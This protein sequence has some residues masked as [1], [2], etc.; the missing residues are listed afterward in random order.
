[1]ELHELKEFALMKIKHAI[2]LARQIH[3]SN[4][5]K[6]AVAIYMGAKQSKKN[7]IK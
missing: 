4:C 1:M 6:N 2:W 5:G 3:Q 7:K